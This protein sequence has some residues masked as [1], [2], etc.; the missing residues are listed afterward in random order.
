MS[1]FQTHFLQKYFAY[2]ARYVEYIVREA[3]RRGALAVVSEIARLAFMIAG[4][5]L[6]ALVFWLL[7][8]GAVRRAGGFG[9][10]PAVFVL[11]ALVP[12]AFATL[13]LAGLANAVR[14]L[15]AVKKRTAP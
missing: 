4:C 3:P 2:R 12:T 13:S 14:A 5:V 7:A 1:A 10:W 6:C 15:G 8:A 9:L 11:C